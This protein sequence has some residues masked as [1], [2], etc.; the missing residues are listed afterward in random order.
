MRFVSDCR[1]QN[2]LMHSSNVL[3]RE[4]LA[5]IDA[6]RGWA[7]LLVMLVHSLGIYPNLPWPVVKIGSFGWY[8]VQMFFV[9]SAL[10]LLLSWHRQNAALTSKV[11]SFF[12]RRFFRIAPMYYTA[13]VAYIFLRPPEFFDLKQFFITLGF[14]NGWSPDWMGVPDSSWQ[15]VPGGWSISVEFSFYFI[16][17]LLALLITTLSRATTLFFLSMAL[18]VISHLAGKAWL[19]PVLSDEYAGRFLFFWFPNQLIVFSIGFI[20]FHL[21]SSQ[22]VVAVSI[23]N[24][25]NLQANRYL[26]LTFCLFIALT[27]FGTDKTIHGDFPWLP[28][29][30]LV[31]ILFAIAALTALLGNT[32]SK[33][34]SNRLTQSIGEVSFSAYL[35]HWAVIDLFRY[36]GKNGIVDTSISGFAAIGLFI[37]TF[38][39]VVTLTFLLSK[40]TYHLIERPFIT[41][42]KSLSK[43]MS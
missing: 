40:I 17:P 28:T 26:L 13:A 7:I 23:R 33:L 31:S 8:G 2:K 18:M 27:Q 20:A 5:G 11:T 14:L 22:T 41:L 4:K 30:V 19:T 38:A 34:Y 32:P 24:S 1:Q 6:T 43:R 39:L 25:F 16:F 42:S 9:A 21:I 36:A 15:V 12:I 3:S 37:P 10:T 29:H 35:I